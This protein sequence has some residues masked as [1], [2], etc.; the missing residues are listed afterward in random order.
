[1]LEMRSGRSCMQHSDM[2]L[3]IITMHAILYMV[4][5]FGILF[6]IVP[7]VMYGHMNLHRNMHHTYACMHMYNI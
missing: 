2:H 7:L 6:I 3:Y 1:M 4:I 5:R